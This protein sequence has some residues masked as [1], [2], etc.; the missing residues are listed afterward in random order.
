MQY[1]RRTHRLTHRNVI[2]ISHFST[3]L[4]TERPAGAKSN[5]GTSLGWH[6]GEQGQ[7]DTGLVGSSGNAFCV[8][9]R[10]RKYLLAGRATWWIG[11]IILDYL[12]LLAWYELHDNHDGLS[13]SC[14]SYKLDDVGVIILFKNSPL[15]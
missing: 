13:L 12:S 11:P 5:R 10:F 7:R 14:Y 9:S 4:S 8:H 6:F 1:L 2:M 3:C 15:L